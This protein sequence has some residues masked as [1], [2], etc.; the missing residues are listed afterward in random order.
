MIEDLDGRIITMG[1]TSRCR[2]E[3]LQ[4]MADLDDWFV[5][6]GLTSRCRAGAA[7]GDRR[8]RRRVR[9][10]GDEHPGAG[11][12]RSRGSRGRK[13]DAGGI[14]STS[15]TSSTGRRGHGFR[16]VLRVR[17]R[18]LR[19]LKPCPATSGNFWRIF[20]TRSISDFYLSNPARIRT[21]TKRTKISCATVTPRS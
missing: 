9:H 11:R 2:S 10:H 6:M 17:Y 7:Q 21:L 14:S 20:V 5:T 3:P 13:M 12:S 18:V 1:L 15:P 16:R 4:G 19:G 8:L